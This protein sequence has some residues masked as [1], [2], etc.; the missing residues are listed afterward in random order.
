MKDRVIELPK[1]IEFTKER[2]D[3]ASYTKPELDR[4]VALCNFSD[5]ELE[6]VALRSK[7]KSNISIYTTMCISESKLHEIRRR[8]ESKI[9]KVS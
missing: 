6:F 4:I 3:L 9:K 2:M 5:D 7:G 1:P 8:V